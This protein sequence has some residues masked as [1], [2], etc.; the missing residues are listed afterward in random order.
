MTKKS[1]IN[2]K[3]QYS[4]VITL[5]PLSITSCPLVQYLAA[6][7]RAG[8][9]EERRKFPAYHY[10]GLPHSAAIRHHNGC[11]PQIEHCL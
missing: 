1:F 9:E 10:C 11:G 6:A 2:N 5:T 4:F 7:V 8:D 3:S